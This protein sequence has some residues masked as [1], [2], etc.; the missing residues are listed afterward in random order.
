L[1]ITEAR[2]AGCAVVATNVGGIPEALDG[3]DAGVLVPPHRS[4][5]LAKAIIT[6][7]DSPSHRE[8]LRR[9]AHQNLEGFSV[10]RCNA[11]T[12]SVYR[13]LLDS[14]PI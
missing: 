9:R 5:I 7:I 8:R 6:L 2:A 12:M 11:Q 3:G 4:D 1:V 10:K 13:E 14:S